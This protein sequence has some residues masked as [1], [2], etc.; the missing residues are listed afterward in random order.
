MPTASAAVT[1]GR[2]DALVVVQREGRR[3]IKVALRLPILIPFALCRELPR[4]DAAGHSTLYGWAPSRSGRRPSSSTG[5]FLASKFLA[6][7]FLMARWASNGAN[8]I[9]FSGNS[10]P[11]YVQRAVQCVAIGQWAHLRLQSDAYPERHDQILTG[12]GP[13]AFLG[14][15]AGV[16]CPLR[17]GSKSGGALALCPLCRS[18]QPFMAPTQRAP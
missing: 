13:P 6:G 4:I 12:I 18:K 9:F 17:V 8:L 11:R 1:T 10:E 16:R 3:F 5:K 15:S 7:R 14:P 2:I